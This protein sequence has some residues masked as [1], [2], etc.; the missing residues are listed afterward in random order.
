MCS[1]FAYLKPSTQTWHVPQSPTTSLSQHQA[2]PRLAPVRTALK[3]ICHGL[4]RQYNLDYSD[5]KTIPGSLPLLPPELLQYISSDFLSPADTLAWS[6]T[7]T[8]ARFLLLRP[9]LSERD[10]YDFQRRVRFSRLEYYQEHCKTE[11]PPPAHALCSF[12]LNVHKVSKF[13]NSQLRVSSSKR[14][15]KIGQQALTQKLRLCSHQEFSYHQIREIYRCL[16][17]LQSLREAGEKQRMI[18]ALKETQ[19]YRSGDNQAGIDWHTNQRCRDCIGQSSLSQFE[20]LRDGQMLLRQEVRFYTIDFPATLNRA[21]IGKS[22]AS[23]TYALCPHLRC[24]LK[25]FEDLIMDGV[26]GVRVCSPSI[27]CSERY[28]D[29]S[30]LIDHEVSARGWDC[31]IWIRRNLGKMHDVPGP[32][33][34]AQ[35]VPQLQ[36]QHTLRCVDA[37]YGQE[38]S[39]SL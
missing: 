34:F 3:E 7:S 10:C 8:K 2:R 30:I 6:M 14:I 26:R 4:Y 25:D 37:G 12:C 32:E 9:Q 11:I 21:V 16:R 33:W 24:R 19:T 1:T 18:E 31:S 29:T 27:S 20:L 35:T 23:A 17:W 13:T 28:C 15:C 38:W 22:L 36:R 39:N 5:K